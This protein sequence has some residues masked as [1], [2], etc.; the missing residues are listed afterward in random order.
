MISFCL[1]SCSIRACIDRLNRWLFKADEYG[2][3]SHSSSRFWVHIHLS[4]S[5]GFWGSCHCVFSWC[6][7]AVVLPDL[8]VFRDVFMCRFVIVVKRSHPGSCTLDYGTAEDNPICG[9]R[10]A[11]IHARVPKSVCWFLGCI[12]STSL[13]PEGVVQHAHRPCSVLQRG[14]GLVSSDVCGP[15][16]RRLIVID[17]SCASSPVCCKQM[18]PCALDSLLLS[19]VWT[20][21][22]WGN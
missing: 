7:W 1:S 10:V 3:S 17:R 2:F 19:R 6:R 20:S 11:E 16:L 5:V 4:F 14:A 8:S 12:R 9:Q 21:W 13:K 15:R 22:S 18:D